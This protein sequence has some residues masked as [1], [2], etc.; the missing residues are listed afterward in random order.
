MDWHIS[1]RK[2]KRLTDENNEAFGASPRGH[3]RQ[4]VEEDG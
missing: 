1:P 4:R 3:H 2:D